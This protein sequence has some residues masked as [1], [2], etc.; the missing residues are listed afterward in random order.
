MKLPCASSRVS[1]AFSCV[2]LASLAVAASSCGRR[3]GSK[4]LSAV[5]ARFDELRAHLS[6]PSAGEAERI[7]RI[8][9][10]GKPGRVSAIPALLH[11]LR[12]RSQAAFYLLPDP[13]HPLGY[14]AV[15]IP[16]GAAGASGMERTA[17]ILSLGRIGSVWMALPDLL[18]ALDDRDPL[19]ANHAAALLV[20]LGSRSGI[21][22]LIANLA[23]R[24]LAA[25]SAASILVELS[26][27]AVAMNPESGEAMKRQAIADAE[28]WWARLQA[29][30]GALA[31]EGRPYQQGQDAEADRRIAFHVDMLGQF[32][33]LY[34]EQARAALRRLGPA[35]LPFLRDG[36]QRAREE[37]NETTRGGIAQVLGAIDHPNGRELLGDLLKDSAAPVRLRA[38]LS[39]GGL[40]GEGALA[41]LESGLEDGDRSVVVSVLR[42]MGRTRLP[43]AVDRL[44]SFDPRGDPDLSRARTLA[45]FE[46]SRGAEEREAVLAMLW[47]PDF[48]S[49]NQAHEA[50]VALFGTGAGYDPLKDE[51]RAREAAARYRRLLEAR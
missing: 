4:E 33:F 6:D 9:E 46:A 49:R 30:G 19:V 3:D 34:H 45:L 42:G 41:A 51:A 14:R 25:E 47:A 15:E 2:L 26:G 21:P 23:G 27:G 5:W 12:D 28:A 31:G 43:R 13:G 24:I 18:L 32:Q 37:G 17:A 50:L 22:V 1:G 35:A 29:G 10:Q 44:K 20:R 48:P 40:G 39:L 36:I 7:D 16:D 8:L 38:A 11:V